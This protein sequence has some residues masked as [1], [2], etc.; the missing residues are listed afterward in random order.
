MERTVHSSGIPVFDFLGPVVLLI[1]ALLTAGYLL[2]VGTRAFFKVGEETELCKAASETPKTMT[3]TV[4]FLA[5]V[6]LIIGIIPTVVQQMIAN[7]G[8][9]F[10]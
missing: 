3:L 4:A 7:M 9:F 6:S 8:I 1:S 10:K 5:M 2:P